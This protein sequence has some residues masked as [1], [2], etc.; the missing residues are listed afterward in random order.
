MRSALKKVDG[1][2]SAD[3]S[4]GKAVVKFDPGKTNEKAIVAAIKGAGYGIAE[5][6]K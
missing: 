3:V 6:K 5:K 2:V 1:I 4:V